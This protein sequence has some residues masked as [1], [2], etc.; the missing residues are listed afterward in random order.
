[1]TM[2]DTFQYLLNTMGGVCFAVEFSCH[3]V[4]E[5]FSARHSGDNRKER[6]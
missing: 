6:I 2:I 1:M 5:E 4:F 3:D